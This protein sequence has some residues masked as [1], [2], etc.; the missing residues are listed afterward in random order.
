MTMW[1]STA[2]ISSLRDGEG[3]MEVSQ[4]QVFIILRVNLGPFS[5]CLLDCLYFTGSYARETSRL[6]PFCKSLCS[7]SHV[8]LI[9]I[10]MCCPF[11][12]FSLAAQF[13]HLL[14]VYSEDKD[15][16]SLNQKRCW[17]NYKHK[18]ALQRGL[19]GE[20]VR[21]KKHPQYINPKDLS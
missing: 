9:H 3:V 10:L 8:A 13:I 4:I 12:Y 19:Q 6:L 2:S 21:G 17:H 20:V 16:E 18:L 7:S 14:V 5:F 15:S 11:I 1:S